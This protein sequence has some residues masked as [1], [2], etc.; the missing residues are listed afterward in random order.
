[1]LRNKKK[2]KKIK[3]FKNPVTGDHINQAE[4]AHGMYKRHISRR[5]YTN[6]T[7]ELCINELY[8]FQMRHNLTDYSSMGWLFIALCLLEYQF[9][10]VAPRPE[11]APEFAD[12]KDVY[13][14]DQ[15]IDSGLRT[16]KKGK[17]CLKKERY[18]LIKWKALP[19]YMASWENEK[20]VNLIQTY[21]YCCYC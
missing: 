19:Y 9:G 15:I 8:G 10:Y 17:N 1:M 13:E 20:N 2:N 14:I 7:Q 6:R 16:V 21:F 4:G 11:L 5:G 12:F 18:Y 3:R